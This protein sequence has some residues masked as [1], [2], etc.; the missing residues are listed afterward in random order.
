MRSI[1]C[2]LLRMRLTTRPRRCGLSCG[3]ANSAAPSRD[4]GKRGPQIVTEYS[5]ELISEEVGLYG[6]AIHRCGEGLVDGFIE[7]PYFAQL[8]RTT[9]LVEV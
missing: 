5:N 1:R 8:R 9:L 6:E 3:N 2:V 4:R 7:P